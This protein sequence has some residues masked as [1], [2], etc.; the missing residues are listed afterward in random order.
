MPVFRVEQ[1][2]SGIAHLVM[3]HPA[4]KVNVLDAEALTDLDLALTE[5][6]GIGR[7]RGVVLRSGKS[8]SFIAGADI[9]AIGALTDRDEVLALIHRAHATFNRLAALPCAT[10]AAID[11][12]C[13]GGGTELALACDTRIA[14]EEPHTQ[15]GLP[16]VLLG[17]F[18]GFGGS[19][20]LPRLI[21]L[22]A[23]L[24][25]ILTGRSLDGRRA[26]KA[27]LVSRT[28]PAAWLIER[29]HERIEALAE[30]PSGQRR[31]AHRPRGA[32]WFVDRTPFGQAIALGKARSMTRARTG[33]HYPAPLAAIEVLERTLRLP[34]EA[35]LEIEASR[36]ADLVVGPV[37]KNLV[38]IFELSERA[39]KEAVADPALKPA[40]VRTLLLAGAGVMGGGIAELASR[41]GIEVRMR[42]LKPEPLTRALLTARS[43]IAERAR[44][45]RG[46][47]DAARE[48]AAQMARIQP[49]LELN[50]AGRADVAM[51]A[52]VEDLEV[53]R[54]VFAELDV[55][56]PAR[57]VLATNTSSLSVDAMAQGL[58]HPERLC[59]FHFFNPVHRMPLVEIVRGRLTSDQTLVTAVALARRL[60]KTPVVV[61]DAPGFVVNRILMPYLG[62]AM[63]LLEE[64][65]ALTDI[66]R[67]MRRFGMPMGPFEVLDEVGLDVATK[68][69]GVLSQAFPDR[70][71]KST[72]LEK[73]VAAG[74]LGHKSGV[75]FYRYAGKKRH[76][77]PTLRRLLG[78][79]RERSG[80]RQDAITERM[81][82]AMIN[83]AS[84]CLEEKVVADAGAV[85]VAMI[86]GA[87]FPPFRGG[88][89]RHADTLGLARV[90]S[91]LIALR[92]EK[93]ERF[94]PSPLLA[95]LAAEGGTFTAPIAGGS[96]ATPH[97]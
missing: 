75:G 14:S 7:L 87:G 61:A 94:A 41:S 35:G 67:A 80:T 96:P 64:G 88:V 52:V 40:P 89:L 18:P 23:A 66:D 48:A 2:V 37:C 78:L 33:G 51:E 34:L 39:K 12:I 16:E 59:G 91:R 82:L 63:V 68:V 58:S 13:L 46:G 83:E 15:I 76:P 95:R 21:G 20:R 29:A 62:E 57:A 93:G 53:K 38:R 25:L 28:V 92:A 50:G 44:R 74:R 54:R 9:G 71:P 24:D 72:S 10:V 45:R 90:E 69:G 3:D 73:L 42:D 84:R 81:V 17:I 49:T 86:F 11:G 8:G 70:S 27:G 79:S 1:P 6:T 5:L 22:A 47:A 97:P 55:R 43:L 30:R 32:A 65:Y 26:E 56:L 36:V 85:D 77:D 19:Q 31:D 4:R 60:G